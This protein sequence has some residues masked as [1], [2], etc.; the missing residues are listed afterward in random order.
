MKVRDIATN[1]VKSCTPSTSIASAGWMMWEA[2]CGILPVVRGD[3][4]AVGVLT[5]R[6]VCMAASTKYRPAGEISVGEVCTGRV[7][8]CGPNDD[9]TDALECMRENNVRRLLVLDT[10]GKPVGLLSLS[11]IALAARPAK[12]ARANDISFDA[13][14]RTYQSVCRRKEMEPALAAP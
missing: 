2:D 1:E 3:G 8:S 11:D 12:G 4:K 13:F 7:Y 10:E 6:D 5:D 14:M 9:V